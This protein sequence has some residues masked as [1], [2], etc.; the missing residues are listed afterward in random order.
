MGEFPNPPIIAGPAPTHGQVP[1]WDDTTDTWVAGTP[2][3]GFPAIDP[4]VITARFYTPA[5][6]VTEKLIVPAEVQEPFG[7]FQI[8]LNAPL[9]TVAPGGIVV[10]LA[11]CLL[12]LERV[13]TNAGIYAISWQVYVVADDANE[14]AQA[15]GSFAITD[16]GPSQG[17]SRDL[18]S[19]TF[20]QI[21]GTDLTE[22]GDFLIVSAAGGEF[23]SVLTVIGTYE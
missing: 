7:P 1:T 18:S 19:S 9:Q 5:F 3:T 2:G 11:D 12:T 15:V 10:S 20:S 16:P 6:V 13:N 4:F 8:N 22:N 17:A 14:S 21:N 23:M